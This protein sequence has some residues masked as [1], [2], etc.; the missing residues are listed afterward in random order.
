MSYTE[1]VNEVRQAED[2][3]RAKLAKHMGDKQIAEVMDLVED[4]KYRWYQ[5][6]R[7]DD[8]S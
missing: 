8:E 7:I 2:K 4:Y 1:L 6:R 3:I 5:L